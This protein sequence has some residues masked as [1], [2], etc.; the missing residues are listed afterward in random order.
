MAEENFAI[1]KMKQWV[2]VCRH[3]TAVEEYTSRQYEVHRVM[4][5]IIINANADNTSFIL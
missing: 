3:V 2:A 1:V 4:Y 5:R